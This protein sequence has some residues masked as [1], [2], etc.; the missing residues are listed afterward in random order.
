MKNYFYLRFTIGRR[1]DV[2]MYFE[3]KVL[4]FDKLIRCR[5]I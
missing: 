5:F 2:F 1:I 4:M 3:K